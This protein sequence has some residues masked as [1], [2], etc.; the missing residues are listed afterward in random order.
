MKK[1]SM[2]LLILCGSCVLSTGCSMPKNLHFQDRLPHEQQKGYVSFVIKVAGDNPDRYARLSCPIVKLEQGHEVSVCRLPANNRQL[3]VT[4]RPGE[5]VYVIHYPSAIGFAGVHGSAESVGYQ[6]G[7]LV[8]YLTANKLE[9]AVMKDRV[10]VQ[11][12]ELRIRITVV[13]NQT[14]VV[15][16][17]LQVTKVPEDKANPSSPPLSGRMTSDVESPASIV[18]SDFLILEGASGPRMYNR[19]GSKVFSAAMT[20]AKKLGWKIQDS[21]SVNKTIVARI[22]RFGSQPLEFDIGMHTQPDG[23]TRVDVSSRM[24]WQQWGTFNTKMSLERINSF[25]K[26][27]DEQL[28]TN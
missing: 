23:L 13:E 16:L 14:T 5:H 26:A 8:G 10:A 22:D 6:G 12:E 21:D 7:G 11:T 24:A 25:Y 20:A 28:A 4:D 15:R 17:N 1:L 3:S 19:D 27:L 2:C 9:P 18:Q